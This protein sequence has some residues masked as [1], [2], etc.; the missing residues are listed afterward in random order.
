LERANEVERFR[1]NGRRVMQDEEVDGLKFFRPIKC[2]EWAL[3]GKK[4]EAPVQG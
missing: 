2:L 1:G 3:S 4:I